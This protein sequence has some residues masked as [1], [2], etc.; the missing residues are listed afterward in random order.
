L[1]CWDFLFW[2]ILPSWTPYTN[3]HV[4][5]V[6]AWNRDEL[7]IDPSLAA[8]EIGQNLLLGIGLPFS[9]DQNRSTTYMIRAS[10]VWQE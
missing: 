10:V 3:R 5:A 6:G 9:F 8:R 4:P 7:Q 2:E 1:G